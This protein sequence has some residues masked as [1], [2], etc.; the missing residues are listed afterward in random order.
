MDA[1]GRVREIEGSHDDVLRI[2]AKAKEAQLPQQSPLVSGVALFLVVVA[3]L[4]VIA[5][6]LPV[7]AIPVIFPDSVLGL[8]ES[9]ARAR[10]LPRSRNRG[11]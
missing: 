6:V 10:H 5:Q 3:V 2:H 7:G 4:L 11:S 9:C 1:R 8:R